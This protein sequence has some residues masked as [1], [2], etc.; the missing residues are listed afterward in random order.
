MFLMFNKFINYSLWCILCCDGTKKVTI[1][2]KHDCSFV[3]LLVINKMLN[4]IKLV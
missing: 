2:D 4:K 3:Y 1:N